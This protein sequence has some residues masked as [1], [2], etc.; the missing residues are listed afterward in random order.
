MIEYLQK[1]TVLGI[2][3]EKQ[4]D[5]LKEIWLVFVSQMLD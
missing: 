1:V 4:M 3:K 5:C 2:S